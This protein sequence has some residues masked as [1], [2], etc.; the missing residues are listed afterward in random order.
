M[1]SMD[2]AAFELGTLPP[3][4]KTSVTL[5]FGDD[6]GLHTTLPVHVVRS[7]S[8]G[9]T[10]LVIAAVHGDEYEGVHTAIRLIR[11]LHP[12][13]IRGT[14]V[15]VPVVNMLAYDGIMRSTP[16]DGCNLARVFPG[17][18]NGTITQR[19]AY[20]L[21]ERFIRHAD[22]LLDLHSG[23]TNYAVPELVGY[24]HNDGS[25]VG[26]RSRTAAEAFGMEVLWAH[27]EVNP[28]RTLT[29]ATELGVPWM[30]TEGFG[31]R[32]IREEE[33]LHY[34]EGVYRLMRHLG[35]LPEGD[36]AGAVPD[37]LREALSRPPRP[38]KWRIAGDGNFDFSVESEVEG[39]FIP[40]AKLL[41]TVAEGERIGAIYDWDGT[42]K[43][44]VIACVDGVVIMLTGT[45]R[46]GKNHFLYMLTRAEA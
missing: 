31:G 13:H 25:E 29:S 44:A 12:A 5:T 1:A 46:V 28:G 14:V 11:D 39:F 34:R 15:V 3:G 21:R 9:P 8:P 26:R 19:L 20:H 30:Y 41:D 37:D 18:P 38:V 33:E 4:S 17:D 22:F 42:E 40:E 27:P 23:G 16:E 2:I 32:R 36:A 6:N 7:A 35:I 45:P 24:Y 43:Q 10:L